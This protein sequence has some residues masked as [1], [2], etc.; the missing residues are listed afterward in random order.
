[1]LYSRVKLMIGPTCSVGL[2]DFDL[3]PHQGFLY[4]DVCESI[5][6]S[7]TLFSEHL[8][9]VNLTRHCPNGNKVAKGSR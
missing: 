4:R 9:V 2:G 5:P 1:M 7:L 8:E 6:L 3:G